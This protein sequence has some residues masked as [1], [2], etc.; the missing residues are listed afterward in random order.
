M[1]P[2]WEAKIIDFRIFFDIFWKYFSNNVVNAK[3]IVK[4]VHKDDKVNFLGSDLRNAR[5]L[6]RDKERGYK[7]LEPE[8]LKEVLDKNLLKKNHQ[9]LTL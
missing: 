1:S 8:I 5:L 9:N 3:K 4:I 2:F 6:G 7:R